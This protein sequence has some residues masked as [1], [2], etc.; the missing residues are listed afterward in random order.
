MH[1]KSITGTIHKDRLDILEENL[2][3]KGVT[4]CEKF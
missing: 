4:E 1:L 2:K 3:S